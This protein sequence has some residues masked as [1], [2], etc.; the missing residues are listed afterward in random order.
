[1]IQQAEGYA[2]DRVNVAEG[3]ADLFRQ[4]F[5][6]LPSSAGSDAPP[7]LSRDNADDSPGSETEDHP[8]R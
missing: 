1:M 5:A 6:V 7:Y 8:R 2:T 4:V 3:D